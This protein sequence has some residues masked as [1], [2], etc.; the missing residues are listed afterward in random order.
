MQRIVS[1]EEWLEARKEL[2]SKE[3]DLTRA[4]DA[5]NVERRELPMVEWKAKKGWSIDWYSS[6]GSD[7]NARLRNLT[8]SNSAGQQRS[9]RRVT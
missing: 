4:R 6:Y 1:R 2:L 8:A 9:I 7:F 3:K 5:L